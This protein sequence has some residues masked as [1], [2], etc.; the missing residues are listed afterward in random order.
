MQEPQSSLSNSVEG[1][2]KESAAARTC[3]AGDI[4]VTLQ[5]DLSMHVG[6]RLDINQL[7]A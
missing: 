2:F 7:K 3:Y 6:S 4:C 5:Y 1:V